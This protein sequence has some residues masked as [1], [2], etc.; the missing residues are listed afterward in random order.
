MLPTV[1]SSVFILSHWEVSRFWICVFSTDYVSLYTLKFSVG[2][3]LTS[4]LLL[5]GMVFLNTCSSEFDKAIMLNL[6]FKKKK[7]KS[8]EGLVSWKF[9]GMSSDPLL[10]VFFVSPHYSGLWASCIGLCNP[11]QLS[12]EPVP[13]GMPDN[14]PGSPHLTKRRNKQT[15]ECDSS[16]LWQPQKPL[17][18]LREQWLWS[19][20]NK[21][22]AIIWDNLGAIK[23]ATHTHFSCYIF[24]QK[25][26]KKKK[27]LNLLLQ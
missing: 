23:S 3:I 27:R 12:E 6:G 20:I 7:K 15:H 16:E 1:Y 4:F 10:W 22:D 2:A 8:S 14:H 24:L 5:P 13:L 18:P 25:K 26:K 21:Q 11:V 17:F 19:H 9:L